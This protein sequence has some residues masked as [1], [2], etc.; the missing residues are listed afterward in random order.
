MDKNVKR[1]EVLA[2]ELN[3]IF[4]TLVSQ[5]EDLDLKRLFKQLEADMMDFRHK[6][7]THVE[8]KNEQCIKS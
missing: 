4:N 7:A 5:A 2:A 1:A 8:V 6:L 3:E